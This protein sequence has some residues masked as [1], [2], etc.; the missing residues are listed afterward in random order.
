M[1][2][3]TSIFLLVIA[4]SLLTASTKTSA[5]QFARPS[6]TISSG[7]WVATGAPTLHEATDETTPNDN[8][9]YAV[10]GTSSDVAELSLSAIADPASSSNHVIRFTMMSMVF[11]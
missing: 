1:D 3:K 5:A 11:K 9:D 4:V 8:T 10:T 7:N 2:K 6:G